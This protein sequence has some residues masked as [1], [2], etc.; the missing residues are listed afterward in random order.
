MMTSHLYPKGG[1]S[2][3]YLSDPNRNLFASAAAHDV[4][5]SIFS[6]ERKTTNSACRLSKVRCMGMSVA[7]QPFFIGFSAASIAAAMIA[8]KSQELPLARRTPEQKLAVR[9]YA[10]L[11]HAGVEQ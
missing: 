5:E 7:S 6:F 2:E 8:D 1:P 9:E 10:I 4:M 11:L 3:A